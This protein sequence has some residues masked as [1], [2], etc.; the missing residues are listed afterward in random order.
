MHSTNSHIAIASAGY[1][2]RSGSAASGITAR[3]E[4]M[5]TVIVEKVVPNIS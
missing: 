2:G 5:I 4:A 3:A 1:L